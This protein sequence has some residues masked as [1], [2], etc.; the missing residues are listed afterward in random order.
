MHS[1]RIQHAML[2]Q[3]ILYSITII[4][5]KTNLALKI[6]DPWGVF[7]VFH[8]QT[9]LLL[10]S[11]AR[12]QRPTTFPSF[13]SLRT[14]L[15]SSCFLL[16][17]ARQPQTCSPHAAVK[18]SSAHQ[19]LFPVFPVFVPLCFH[20]VQISFLTFFALYVFIFFLCFLFI[21]LSMLCFLFLFFF[22]SVFLFFLPILFL[23]F[24]P[25]FLPLH[26]FLFWFLFP[27][28]SYFSHTFYVMVFSMPFIFPLQIIEYFTSFEL[29]V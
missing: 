20:L 12:M 24:D 22:L 13:S 14:N 6:W 26:F 28:F 21:F 11:S 17:S 15:P 5:S 23:F 9:L 25:V 8:K 29:L 7:W 3:R 27:C 18:Q 16:I 10:Y 19:I 2:L 1:Q 4:A